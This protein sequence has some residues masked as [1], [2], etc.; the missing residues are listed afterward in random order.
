MTPFSYLVTHILTGKRYYGCRYAK[1]SNPCQLGKTYFTS[2]KE[3][4]Q[5][6]IKEGVTNFTFEVRKVFR[7]VLLCR[8]WEATVLR[9][10]KAAQSNKW[11]NRSNGNKQFY[12][13]GHTKETSKKMSQSHTGYHHSEDTKK[14]ISKSHLGKTGQKWTLQ[15]KLNASIRRTG[16]KHSED[17]KKKIGNSQKGKFV[18][19]WSNERKKE[20]SSQMSGFGNNFYGKN[21]SEETKK[22]M[23]DY[24]ATVLKAKC[25]Y[26]GLEAIPPLIKRWH[27]EKCKERYI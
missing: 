14:K 19:R 22:R 4:R 21:H 5:L 11:F 3:L 1:N 25:K 26:C 23:K 17:T 7:D 12:C 18:A 13:L 20:Y 24:H 27:N 2:C 8:K 15:Q 16:R 9:R 6:I 10:L